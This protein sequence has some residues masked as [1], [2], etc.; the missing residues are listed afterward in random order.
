MKDIRDTKSIVPDFD[1]KT[2]PFGDNVSAE[3]AYK[4]TERIVGAIYLVTNH[5]QHDEPLRK[6]LR[7]IGHNLLSEV[8]TLRSGFRSTSHESRG[9]LLSDLREAISLIHLLQISGYVSENNASLLVHAMDDL[10]AFLAGSQHSVL[11]DG[12]QLQRDDFIPTRQQKTFPKR[13]SHLSTT[14]PLSV[15]KSEDKRAIKEAVKK[16]PKT[17]GRSVQTEVHNERRDLIMDILSKGGPLG[18]KDIASQMVGCS[19][20]TVQRELAVLIKD[21]IVN[22]SGEKRWSSYTL[23]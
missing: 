21:N 15:S 18:I 3:H 19:E 6:K 7:S 11:S 23:V 20:K 1:T 13:D 17:P 16:T 5:V 22:K 12:I 14:E 2:D 4:R 8:I 10:G 9:A